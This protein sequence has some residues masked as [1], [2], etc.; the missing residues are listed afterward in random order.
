MP[1]SY[2]KPTD[3]RR[4]RYDADSPCVSLA[5]RIEL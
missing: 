2:G 5:I 1:T 3:E 4:D